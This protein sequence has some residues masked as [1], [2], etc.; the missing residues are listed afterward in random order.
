M[1]GDIYSK[2]NFKRKFKY[3]DKKYVIQTCIY[4]K[5]GIPKFATTI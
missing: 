2:N 1:E 5:G 4:A 3:Q